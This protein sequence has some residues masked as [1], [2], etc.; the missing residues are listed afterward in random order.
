MQTN[1]LLICLVF[2]LFSLSACGVFNEN[3][4]GMLNQKNLLD[5]KYRYN[6]YRFKILK[7]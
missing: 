6:T 3:L 2:N 5:N 7:S 4:F 1:R